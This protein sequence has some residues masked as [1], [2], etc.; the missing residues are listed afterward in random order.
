MWSKRQDAILI[1]MAKRGESCSA[2]GQEVGKSA[3]S[4]RIKLQRLR[5][6]CPE[7]GLPELMRHPKAWSEERNAL[8]LRM[9]GEGASQ[10]QIAIACD[11][12]V[13]TVAGKLNRWRKQGL[14]SKRI[15][16]RRTDK[17]ARQRQAKTAAPK[18]ASLPAIMEA[19]PEPLPIPAA[20]DKARISFLQLKKGVCHWP[21]GDVQSEEFG[22]CG[23]E[24]EGTYCPGHEKRAYK[25]PQDRKKRRTRQYQEAPT[26]ASG[27]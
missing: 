15:T 2:I 22:F 20:D 1:G 12:C 17:E 13:N 25:P 26:E 3:E 14:I 18:K 9:H 11:S 27:V 19:K 21:V 10:K 6:A 16:I 7:L 24:C 23:L 8:A 4:V 5:E